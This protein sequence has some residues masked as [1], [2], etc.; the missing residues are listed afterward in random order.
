MITSRFTPTIRNASEKSRIP[1]KPTGTL[2]FQVQ[3]NYQHA[4]FKNY[5]SSKITNALRETLKVVVRKWFFV[6]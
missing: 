6:V 5:F 2:Q 1:F 3:N 4:Q